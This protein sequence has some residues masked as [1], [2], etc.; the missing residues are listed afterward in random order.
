MR[1]PPS[2]NSPCWVE[3]EDV[4]ALG[5]AGDPS[6]FLHALELAAAR[7]FRLALH[8]VVVIITTPRTDEK[9]SGK[10]RRRACAYFGDGGDITRHR[11]GVD[12]RRLGEPA[13]STVSNAL[14]RGMAVS[15]DRHRPV[16]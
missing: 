1:L 5:A 2:I 10:Q 13:I 8:V 12:E 11:S 7:L 15:I 9:G 4:H 6:A 16:E 14:H 3:G